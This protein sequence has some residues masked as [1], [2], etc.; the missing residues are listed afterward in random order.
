VP[1]PTPVD[2]ALVV[3][4]RFELGRLLG[5]GASSAVFEARDQVSHDS[6]ALKMLHPHL[7]VRDD[8]VARFARE[9]SNSPEAPHPNLVRTRALGTH[10]TGGL[11]QA[12]MALDL[13]P[14]TTLAESVERLGPLTVAEALIVSTAALRALAA[15]HQQGLV[16]RDVSPNNLMVVRQAGVTL[17]ASDV[18]LIDYGLADA[19]GRV[20]RDADSLVAGSV[21][22]I[23]PE[24]AR[25]LA[26]DEPADLYA[27]AAVLFFCITGQVPFPRETS[28]MTLRAQVN[29]PPPL[30]SALRPGVSRELDGLIARGMSKRPSARFDSAT[31]M[32]EAVAELLGRERVDAPIDSAAPTTVMPTEGIRTR[33]TAPRDAAT[34]RFAISTVRSTVIARRASSGPAAAPLRVR[35]E[36]R[37]ANPLVVLAITL[38]VAVVGWG[39]VAA[40]LQAPPAPTIAAPSSAAPPIEQAAAAPAVAD[41]PV[42]LEVPDLT[43]LSVADAQ[44]KLAGLGLVAGQVSAVDGNRAANTVVSTLPAAGDWL[45]PGDA[46]SLSYASGWNSVPDVRALARDEA[47]ATLQAA[48]FAVGTATVEDP[49]AV[50]GAVVGSSPAPAERLVLGSTVTVLIAFTTP[51]PVP[52]PSSVP[53]TTPVPT[54]S[55]PPTTPPV[56]P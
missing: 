55:A 32:L 13:A 28:E 38:G 48:G 47:V 17:A 29:S 20:G 23:S 46:V 50:T 40:M 51:R 21:N 53:T 18:R 8:E 15:L 26:V 1:D 44:Q 4:G 14:G 31:Q 54:I 35:R 42:L 27:V 34:E 49:V 52:T 33:V 6:V 37:R 24:Q 9:A 3:G 11:S 43:S 12:W 10:D 19:P 56:Q 22:F 2:D 7:S 30:P 36:R 5:S 25:G 41:E 45:A 16:H 39:V